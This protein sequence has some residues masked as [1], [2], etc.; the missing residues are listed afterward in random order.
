[1]VDG[2]LTVGGAPAVGSALAGN[3]GEKL[4]VE[5]NF[6]SG[7]S[8]DATDFNYL[9]N[10]VA[11]IDYGTAQVDG[12]NVTW[13][14]YAG[15]IAFDTSGKA[16]AIDFHPFAFANG[17]ATLISSVSGTAAFSTVVGSSTVT[18]SGNLG[19]SVT[20][21]VGINLSSAT[22]TSYVLGV[23]DANA[24][25][26]TGNLLNG[27]PVALSTFANGTPLAGTCV[28]GS[29]TVSA[30]GSAAGLLIGP[31]AKGLI[32]S[33]ALSTTTGQAVAGAVVMSRP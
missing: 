31:A 5:D 22:V 18:A 24:R 9:A 2:L 26:W 19:G 29:G 17:G 1:M 3:S 15:G 33:Y 4:L 12:V 23:T 28:C 8:N 11:P 27:T 13:G 14:I 30:N 16:I 20:L 6:P 32:S 25:A 21:N 7:Y 10:D